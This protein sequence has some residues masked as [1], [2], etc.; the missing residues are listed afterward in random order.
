MALMTTCQSKYDCYAESHYINRFHLISLGSRCLPRHFVF[1]STLKMVLFYQTTRRQIPEYG[2]LHVRRCD[3]PKSELI[4]VCYVDSKYN[5]TGL[6]IMKMTEY[7][8][9]L[10]CAVITE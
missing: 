7:F 9:S 3:I 10:S 2:D 8:L 5:L 4:S 6:N 1:K